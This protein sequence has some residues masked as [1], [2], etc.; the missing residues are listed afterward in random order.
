MPRIHSTVQTGSA[1]F[2]RHY[3]HNRALALRFRDEEQNDGRRLEPPRRNGRDR[4]D[5]RRHHLGHECLGSAEPV[6]EVAHVGLR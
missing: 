3:A 2:R 6:Q 4:R 1:D 5:R